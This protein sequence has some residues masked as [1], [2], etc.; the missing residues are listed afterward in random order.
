[1]ASCAHIRP[2][3]V[4]SF[5]HSCF[6]HQ[7]RAASNYSYNDFS[8]LFQFEGPAPLSKFLANSTNLVYLVFIYITYSMHSDA[9]IFCYHCCWFPLLEFFN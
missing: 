6:N 2:G 5:A 1:L 4:I 7:R 9:I 3:I 8:K